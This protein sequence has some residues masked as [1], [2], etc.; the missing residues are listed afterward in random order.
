MMDNVESAVLLPKEAAPLDRYARA[1]AKGPG[2]YVVALYYRPSAPD[3]A[4]CGTVLKRQ[5]E[6]LIA[7]QLCPATTRHG[8]GATVLVRQSGA[9]RTNKTGR[10][11]QID[12]RDDMD[13]HRVVKADCH[14]E[15]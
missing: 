4:L 11:V 9:A 8:G 5:A 3:L 13:R 2:K 15:A 12:I 14:D 7:A 10:C 1:Y 6:S